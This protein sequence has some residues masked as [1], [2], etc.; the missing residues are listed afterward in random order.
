VS[1]GGSTQNRGVRRVRREGQDRIQA[2][3]G[4]NGCLLID[5]EYGRVLRRIQ[6]QTDDVSGFHFELGIVAGHVSFEAM[7]L[8]A[9]FLPNAMHGI[10]ADVQCRGQ[11][12]A[13]PV[14]GA[15]TGLSPRGGQDTGAQSGGLEHWAFGQDD[16]CPILQVQIAGSAAS[17]E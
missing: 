12:A 14:R 2:V 6:V 17:S 4:L 15:V 7:R 13:T 10:F 11:L 1:R 5:A 3:Q 9:G 8:E 16:R